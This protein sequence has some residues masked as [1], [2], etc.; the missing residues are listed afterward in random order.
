MFYGELNKIIPELTSNTL[1]ICSTVYIFFV[2]VDTLI[3]QDNRFRYEIITC[4]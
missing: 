2:C 1:L 3:E 4:I